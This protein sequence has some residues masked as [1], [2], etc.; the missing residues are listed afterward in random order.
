MPILP[1]LTLPCILLLATVDCNLGHFRTLLK[2]APSLARSLGPIGGDRQ[3][4]IL[5]TCV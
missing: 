3:F 4:L 5:A 1:R 2:Y